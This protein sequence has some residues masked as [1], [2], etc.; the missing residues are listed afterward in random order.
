M[1]WRLERVYQGWRRVSRSEEWVSWKEEGVNQRLWKVS[2][3]SERSSWGWNDSAEDGDC[4]EELAEY[5]GY[6]LVVLEKKMIQVGISRSL[7]QVPTGL[8]VQTSSHCSIKI[9]WVAS[10]MVKR[11]M[12]L[13]CCPEFSS[14]YFVLT[15]NLKFFSENLALIIRAGQLLFLALIG[16]DLYAESVSFL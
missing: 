4:W 9:T 6:Q 1:N 12:V 16:I 5:S 3:E 11:R 7:E 8:V 14:N 15:C 13:T 10:V 2:W